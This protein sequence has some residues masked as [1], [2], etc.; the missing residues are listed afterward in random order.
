MNNREGERMLRRIYGY[1]SNTVDEAADTAL[2]PFCIDIKEECQWFARYY[3]DGK[4]CLED[5]WRRE[6]A[7]NSAAEI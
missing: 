4:D 3:E 2:S 1:L 5:V 7:L 6:L